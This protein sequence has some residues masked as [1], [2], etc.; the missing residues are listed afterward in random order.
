MQKKMLNSGM[1]VF[2]DEAAIHR[3]A[4]RRL[5][6]G[7][8]FAVM[9]KPELDRLMFDRRPMNSQERRLDWVLLLLE[10]QLTWLVLGKHSG[11]RGSGDDARAYFYRLRA[12]PGSEVR[13]TF[14]PP[15]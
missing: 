4:R 3:D 15:H 1:A 5:L 9:H 11:L 7:G 14:R 13:N 10:T 8:L 2:V 6:K 12:A